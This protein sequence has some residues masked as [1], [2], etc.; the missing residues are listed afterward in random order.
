MSFWDQKGL[1]AL[2]WRR[3]ERR[4]VSTWLNLLR[5]KFWFIFSMTVVRYEFRLVVGRGFFWIRR[6][7]KSS[8]FYAVIGVW[9][10]IMAN[11]EVLKEGF[12]GLV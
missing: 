12:G 2:V 8:E 3:G 4:S 10:R 11:L 9:L 1:A 6:V 7:W 5:G